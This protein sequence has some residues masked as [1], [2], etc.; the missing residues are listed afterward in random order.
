M[1]NVHLCAWLQVESIARGFG[2]L[3]TNFLYTPGEYFRPEEL[4]N[5]N[6]ILVTVDSFSPLTTEEIVYRI[7]SF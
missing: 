4:S 1:P 2:N 3:I 6:I 7:C 5:A